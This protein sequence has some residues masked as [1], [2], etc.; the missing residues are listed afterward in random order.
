MRTIFFSFF[1]RRWRGSQ[2]ILSVSFSVCPV[3]VC[4]N[5]RLNKHI[6]NLSYIPTVALNK[7]LQLFS[8]TP[9][10]KPTFQ[11][12][13]QMA[14]KAIKKPSHVRDVQKNAFTNKGKL[15]V[16]FMPRNSNTKQLDLY[17][18]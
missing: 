3:C 6:Q 1:L 8:Y 11:P 9:P 2:N 13:N 10:A 17:D 16:Y 12:D 7:K 15:C 14:Q 18:N 5:T 4:G